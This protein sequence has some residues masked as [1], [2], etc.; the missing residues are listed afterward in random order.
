MSLLRQNDVVKQFLCNNDVIITPCVHWDVL[1][2]RVPTGQGQVITS[3]KYCG[4]YL[5][6]P[7]IDT[8]I[9]TR[10]KLV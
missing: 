6:V 7:S 9:H 10:L 8:S 1:Y 4:M 3:H 2:V 5:L